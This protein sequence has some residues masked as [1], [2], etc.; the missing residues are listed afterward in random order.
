[1]QVNVYEKAVVKFR[2]SFRRRPY[3]CF[4]DGPRTRSFF[5]RRET[6]ELR[7]ASTP[8]LWA[9]EEREKLL[10]FYERVSRARMHASFIRPVDIGTVTAQ[11]AK[12]WG[13][14]GVM[15]R[16]SGVCWDLRKAAPY[17]VHDQLE[18]DIP[19]G[20][21]GDCFDRYSIRIEEMRQSVRII[22]QCLN[23]VPSGMI[24]ADDRK[25]C[26]PSRSRMK[27]SMESCAMSKASRGWRI[28]L[29]VEKHWE[30][31]FF[32]FGAVSFSV[33]PPRHSASLPVLRK[34]Q[35][36][37][38]FFI[39][40]EEKEP[41]TSWEA[42]HRVSGLMRITKLARRSWLLAQQGGALP[43]RRRK[44]GSVR[45]GASGFQCIASKIRTSLP[46]E[47]CR[48]ILE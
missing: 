46:A 21:R 18:P 42:R 44:R 45:G 35:L 8:F 39:D 41:S 38:P 4:Y 16:G 14:S 13:F 17:D 33:S 34:N 12:D 23:Q 32:F 5:S 6:F 24:K 25:L 1:M 43:H 9:F 48:P 27:L 20:T 3:L 37:S 7:G 40:L 10:E 2:S 47:H 22:V 31:Q 30:P 26:P 28:S 19:V 36:M 11:Q 29:S 15:I